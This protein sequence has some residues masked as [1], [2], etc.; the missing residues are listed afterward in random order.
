M[1]E[2]LPAAVTDDPKVSTTETR[3][4]SFEDGDSNEHDEDDDVS[5]RNGG[6]EAGDEDTAE[7]VGLGSFR[8]SEAT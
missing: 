6:D 1:R 2:A 4:A 7:K 5:D 3:L 8:G